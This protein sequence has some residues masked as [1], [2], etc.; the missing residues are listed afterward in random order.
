MSWLFSGLNVRKTLM[1]RNQDGSSGKSISSDFP[2]EPTLS[3]LPD[4]VIFPIT[5]IPGGNRA[6]TLT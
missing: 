3:S 6:I 2:N 4:P 1:S 5:A